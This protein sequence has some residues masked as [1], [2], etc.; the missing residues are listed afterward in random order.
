MRS[1][2]LTEGTPILDENGEKLGKSTV[3]GRRAVSQ[4]VLS[5]ILMASPGM[6]KSP[7][8][9][10]VLCCEDVFCLSII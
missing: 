4:V 9:M 5:R 1:A 6:S 10:I 8:N 7:N 2:E 3:V